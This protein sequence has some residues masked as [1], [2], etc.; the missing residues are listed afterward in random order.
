MRVVTYQ[1]GIKHT[2]VKPKTARFN[3]V[4][5]QSESSY[6]STRYKLQEFC[7]LIRMTLFLEKHFTQC[8]KSIFWPNFPLFVKSGRI[9]QYEHIFKHSI[10]YLKLYNPNQLFHLLMTFPALVEYLEELCKKNYHSC[11]NQD[12]NTLS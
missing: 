3:G 9:S 12:V 6:Y 2:C 1:S 5:S 8:Y 4:I 7:Q 10:T 11:H